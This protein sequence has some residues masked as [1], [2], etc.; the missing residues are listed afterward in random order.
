MLRS[1]WCLTWVL[2]VTLSILDDTKA[3]ESVESVTKKLESVRSQVQGL[4]AQLTQRRGRAELFQKRLADIEINIGKVS[5]SLFETSQQTQNLQSTLSSLQNHRQI[6]QQELRLERKALAQQI[7]V[8]YATGRQEKLKLLLNQENPTSVGRNLVY[9]D[10]LNKSRTNKISLAKEKLDSLQNL[11]QE[12]TS[13]ATTLKRLRQDLE[14]K[15]RDLE[16]ARDRRR[17]VLIEIKQTIDKN[18]KKLDALIVD[19]RELQQL[20]KSLQDIFRELPHGR[21]RHGLFKSSKGKLGWPAEGRIKKWFGEIRQNTDGNLKWQGVVI[22]AQAGDAVYAIANGQVAFAD[23]MRG[24]GLLLIIDHG[25]G[26]MSLYGYNQSLYKSIGD[27]IDAGDL[28]ARAGDS[29]GQETPGLYFE[30]RHD[31]KPLDPTAWCASEAKR[32]EA[33]NHSSLRN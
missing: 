32:S 12:I 10:Y 30:I 16:T 6:L 29:G 5:E 8:A 23:W 17:N 15:K 31:G 21:R 27:W 2:A 24:Y 20:L 7:R 25:E 26:Y 4:Q 33:S 3:T 14:K 19:E 22:E 9:Y 18:Q 28:I 1:L 11:E 13:K